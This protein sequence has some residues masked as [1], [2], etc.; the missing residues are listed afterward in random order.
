M[1][2]RRADARARAQVVREARRIRLDDERVL[3]RVLHMHRGDGVEGARD[4]CVRPIRVPQAVRPL[5]QLGERVEYGVRLRLP[6]RE[7]AREAHDGVDRAL[8]EVVDVH[9]ARGVVRDER[10]VRGGRVPVRRLRVHA[11]A[12]E[13]LRL[14]RGCDVRRPRRELGGERGAE[15]RVHD[16]LR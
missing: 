12:V 2:V 10:A 11:R 9:E 7:A 8:A 13:D 16:A 1:D 4:D 3:R 14:E 5:E 15:L 6:A